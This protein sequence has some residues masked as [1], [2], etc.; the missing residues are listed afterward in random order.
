MGVDYC[1]ANFYRESSRGKKSLEHFL[2]ENGLPVENYP[3]IDFSKKS[4]PPSSFRDYDE[5]TGISALH[6]ELHRGPL[7]QETVEGLFGIERPPTILTT[8]R[9]VNH[10]LYCDVALGA[11]QK[12]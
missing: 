9:F 5:N 1:S 2:A 10:L 3:P 8:K 7:S 6:A 4:F 12:L 11:Q